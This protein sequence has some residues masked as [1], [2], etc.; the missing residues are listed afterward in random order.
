MIFALSE[1]QKQISLLSADWQKKSF[2]K[3]KE[4][5]SVQLL[6]RSLGLAL[7]EVSPQRSLYTGLALYNLRIL[8]LRSSLALMC[9][10]TSAVWWVILL[11]LLFMNF[12]GLFLVGL[13]GV[14]LFFLFQRRHWQPWMRLLL[15]SGLFLISG[16]IVIRN[17]SI[18]QTLLTPTGPFG[19]VAFFLADGRFFAILILMAVS[20]FLGLFIQVEFWSFV[21]ALGLLMTNTLSFNGALA[22]VAGERLAQLLLFWW[23]TRSL[24]QDCRRVGALFAAASFVGVCLGFLLAGEARSIFL[25]GFSAEFSATQEKSIHFVILFA[26]ILAIQFLAQMIWGHFGSKFVVDELQDPKYFPATW[27]DQDL[28]STSSM[29]WAKDKVSKRLSEVRY[30]LAGLQSLKEGQVPE[31]LQNRLRE[32]EKQLS[33]I[34]F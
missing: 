10:S 30:H 2:D 16:E 33:Q 9:T 8:D 3:L 26:V 21:L 32:E 22:L 29:A 34:L 14:G 25:L 23:R 27:T 5:S 1:S 24:N 18:L 31:P 28:L 6:M 20:T 19:D 12:N 15:F 13:S 17:S 11:G 7:A 4:G